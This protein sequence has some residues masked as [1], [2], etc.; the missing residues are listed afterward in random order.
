MAAATQ[1]PGV[2]DA[3]S[4]YTLDEVHQRLGLGKT[5]LRTARR[6]GLIVKRIGRR[7][8][9][10]GADLLAWFDRAAQDVGGGR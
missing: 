1:K 4:L 10:R 3:N 6:Q 2:I 5:A 8:Y 7:G 9:V